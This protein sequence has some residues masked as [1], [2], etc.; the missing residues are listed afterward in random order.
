MAR[1]GRENSGVSQLSLMNEK[2]YKDF[3]KEH[4]GERKGGVIV[5]WNN[6]KTRAFL[7]RD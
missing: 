6:F 4:K 7:L 1:L 2:S 5:V 3:K